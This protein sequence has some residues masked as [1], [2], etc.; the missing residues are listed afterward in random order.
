MKEHTYSCF[1]TS[2][3]GK[4]KIDVLATS[5][6]NAATQVYRYGRESNI[7]I[8]SIDGMGRIIK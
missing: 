5:F 4:K 6:L 1:I 7:I 2:S 8:Y 3:K